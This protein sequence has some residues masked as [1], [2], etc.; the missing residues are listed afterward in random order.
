[1]YEV[2][3]LQG[4]IH[5]QLLKKPGPM[6]QGLLVTKE[7]LARI[8]GLDEEIVALQEW[9]T[10]IR[11]AKHYR[12]GFVA[13]ATFVWD[14]RGTD[15]ITKDRRRDAL[16]YEQVVRKHFLSMLRTGPATL[17]NHY[18]KLA[19]RYAEAGAKPDAL[20]SKLYAKLWR[21]AENVPR[22]FRNARKSMD[23]LRNQERRG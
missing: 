15:T 11:L 22:A 21:F 16:G 13:A 18:R 17:S 4:W 7:A 19:Q 10:S 1:L 8:G 20:R 3:P 23:S 2:A 9:E 5:A 6:F 14:C 12:F